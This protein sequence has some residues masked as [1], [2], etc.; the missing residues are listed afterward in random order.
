MYPVWCMEYDIYPALIFMLSNT[1]SY[2]LLF[3]FGMICYEP[4]II[5]LIVN[6]REI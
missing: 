5:S 4:L 2:I 6:V 3:W 1:W